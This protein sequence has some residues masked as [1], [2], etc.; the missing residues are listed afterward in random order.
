MCPQSIYSDIII[1]TALHTCTHHGDVGL[2]GGEISNEGIVEI[3]LNGTWVS[4]CDSS[5]SVRESTV[6]CRQLTGELNPSK[7]FAQEIS[8]IVLLHNVFIFYITVTSAI[9]YAGYIYHSVSSGPPYFT[10]SCSGSESHL[11]NCSFSTTSYCYW[12]YIAGV[13]CYGKHYH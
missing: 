7:K 11:L 10:S 5:W 13:R 2:V 8:F 1:F 3:C 4:V 6:V 9:R 12:G